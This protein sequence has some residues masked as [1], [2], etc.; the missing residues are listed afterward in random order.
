MKKL[1]L[2]ALA[3]MVAPCGFCA[4]WVFN[5]SSNSVSDGDWTFNAAV[6]GTDITFNK[7]TGWP[8]SITALDFSKPVT[9]QDGQTTYTIVKINPEFA[10]YNGL[11]SEAGNYVGE[12]TM[13][14]EG[15]T[16]L[17]GYAFRSCKNAYGDIVL[18]D[19]LAI[20]P[21]GTFQGTKITSIV[22]GKS[23]IN[24][25]PDWY[26]HIANCASLSN[27]IF[28]A[29]GN[30]SI[31]AFQFFAQCTSLKD[32]DLSGVV[33]ITNSSVSGT[34]YPHLAGCNVLTNVTFGANLVALH[35][36]FFQENGNGN[37]SRVEFLGAPPTAFEMP[38]LNEIKNEQ[39]VLTVIP[40]DKKAE[41]AQYVEDPTFADEQTH[42]KA[43]FLRDGCSPTMRPIRTSAWQPK[44]LSGWVYA[45]KKITYGDWQFNATVSGI[46]LTIGAC[47]SD[48]GPGSTLDFTLPFQDLDLDYNVVA[49]NTDFNSYAGKGNVAAVLLPTNGLYTIGKNAFQGTAIS[50]AL[51]LPLVTELGTRAFYGTAITSVELGPNLKKILSGWDSGPFGSCVSLKKVVFDPTAD[52][53]VSSEGMIFYGCSSL[54]YV[55]FGGVKNFA[56]N[57]S[58][59]QWFNQ[60]A[61]KTVILHDPTNINAFAFNCNATIGMHIYGAAPAVATGFS[62]GSQSSTV[63]VH[64]DKKDPDYKAKR[65]SWNELTEEGELGYESTWKRALLS[66]VN[67]SRLLIYVDHMNVPE[68]GAFVK[69]VWR[70]GD[71]TLSFYY[72]T[73]DYSQVDG[74]TTQYLALAAP[75][76]SL[77]AWNNAK[78]VP[79]YSIKAS[80]EKVVFDEAFRNYLPTS[81][82]QWFN[83]CDKLAMIEGIE[84]FNTAACTAMGQMFADCGFSELDL[85]HFR[86]RKVTGMGFMLRNMKVTELDVS[87][88][89]T[90][91]VTDMS[92][93]FLGNT[94]LTTIYASDKF[95]TTKVSNS[96]KMFQ[97]CVSLKGGAGTVYDSSKIDKTYARVDRGESAPGYFTR[98]ALR[99]GLKFILR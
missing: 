35:R 9:S 44:V 12:I 48:P 5:A 49:I 24:L 67:Q 43:E 56:A 1:V 26:P 41:W 63:F 72:D 6:N 34:H 95:V 90:S 31:S 79:E 53:D 10:D 75:P 11:K 38:Y 84:N 88:F 62:I 28:T 17:G 2:A 7:H 45:D 92:Q 81:C 55:D 3:A 33:S 42:W 52:V 8:T 86:T 25:V 91:N 58:S 78:A 37:L 98:K 93:M 66:N 57:N 22:F 71:K 13:P 70:E 46:D 69:A 19:S 77:P 30:I 14:G 61:L 85:S 23:T 47:I 18:P 65:A 15:L 80:L 20:M 94:A 16:E 27:V 29:G 60:N 50:G 59:R 99:R 4:D 97:N 83:G 82:Q 96:D 21:K 32:I 64:L 40:A 36:L 73:V 68:P 74:V 89:D 87:S 39:K 51:K 76:S 54:E